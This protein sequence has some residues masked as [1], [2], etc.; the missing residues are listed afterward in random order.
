MQDL[1]FQ[2]VVQG[3]SELPLPDG[4]IQYTL[5]VK[6]ESGIVTGQLN[7]VVSDPETSEL[8]ATGKSFDVV[9]TP[10]PDESSS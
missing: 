1:R 4:S 3:K 6:P 2:V 10:A 8:V 5:I 9:M 7:I